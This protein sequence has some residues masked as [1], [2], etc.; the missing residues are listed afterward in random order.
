MSAL[1]V[2]GRVCVQS[3]PLTHDL[4]KNS[5]ALAGF[6][7]SLNPLLHRRQ[8]LPTL[9]EFV[10]V[11]IHLVWCGVRL[12]D[13]MP[14]E[15]V[16]P[17]RKEPGSCPAIAIVVFSIA[18]TVRFIR[19]QLIFGSTIAMAPGRIYPSAEHFLSK[20]MSELAKSQGT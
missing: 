11:G 14:H 16:G 12:R 1:R 2:Y 18:I 15:T 17:R 9:V 10:C 19:L 5:L 20:R 7:V 4:M 6:K 3:R 13:G 8:Y